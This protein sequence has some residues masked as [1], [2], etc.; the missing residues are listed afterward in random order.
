MRRKAA[1]ADGTTIGLPVCDADDVSVVLDE[2]RHETDFVVRSGRWTLS[3]L[4][5]LRV[6]LLRELCASSWSDI[7]QRTG[8][9][10]QGVAK[11]HDRHRRLVQEST[12]Y[13]ELVARLSSA[14]LERC[15]EPFRTVPEPFIDTS[16]PGDPER[17]VRRSKC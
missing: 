1:L 11:I 3:A 2:H 15:H 13:S 17:P 4:P 10:P 9:T 12:R 8:T 6:G 14:A 5:H 16:P 7:G